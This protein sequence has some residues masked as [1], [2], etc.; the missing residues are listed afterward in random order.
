MR[1]TLFL[2]DAHLSVER[3]AQIATFCAVLGRATAL[4]AEVYI[5]GDLVEFWLGDDDDAPTMRAVVAALAEYSAAGGT[6]KVSLGNRDFLFGERFCA[7]TGATLLPDYLT[8]QLHGHPVLLTHGDLLCTRDLKYQAF[9]GYVRDPQN[10][11][12]FLLAPLAQR[13]QIAAQM[14]EGTQASMLE[15]NDDIMDVDADEVQRVMLA[16]GVTTLIHGH[17]HRPAVHSF[18]LPDGRPGLRYVL[19][20]WYRT[21]TVLWVADGVYRLLSTTEFVPPNGALGAESSV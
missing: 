17:T 11:Q 12:K 9:R 13:R 10:Q 16:Q 18:S 5:L 15:K 3:P 14:R 20:D 2:S 8:V 1:P 19:G 7:E 21:G 6:L 4:G